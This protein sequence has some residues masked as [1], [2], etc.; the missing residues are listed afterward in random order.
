MSTFP[1]P[2]PGERVSSFPSRPSVVLLPARPRAS[3]RQPLKLDQTGSNPKSPIRPRRPPPSFAKFQFLHLLAANYAKFHLIPFY[4]ELK[5]P[6]PV[7]LH[8]NHAPSRIRAHPN[9]KSSFP[10]LAF[11]RLFSLILAYSHHAANLSVPA[12]PRLTRPLVRLRGIG[13]PPAGRQRGP[14]PCGQATALSRVV[15]F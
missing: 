13:S 3:P 15:S 7:P 14:R 9:R 10:I 8:D 5:L 2:P 11:S 12:P 4:H 6:D 1:N